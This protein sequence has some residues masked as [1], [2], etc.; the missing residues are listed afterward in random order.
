MAQ[1]LLSKDRN[2]G[3]LWKVLAESK[4]RQ[5][6]LALDAFREALRLLPRDPEVCCSYGTALREA[7]NPHTAVTCYKLAIGFRPNYAAAHCNLGVAFEILKQFGE[8]EKSYLE[9]LRLA[10]GTHQIHNNLALLYY[11]QKRLDE[12]RHHCESALGLNA[13]SKELHVGLANISM[14]A[15]DLSGA[16]RNYEKAVTE[17]GSYPDGELNLAMLL[18]AQGQF[19][20]GWPYYEARLDQRRSEPQRTV[21]TS[22]AAPRWSGEDILDRSILLHYEQGFGD[23]VQFIRYVVLLKERGAARVDLFCPIALQP[24]LATTAGIDSVITDRSSVGTYDFWCPTCSLPMIFKTT[25]DSI[26]A[27]T[28]YLYPLPERM[29]RW[30]VELKSTEPK[31]GLVWKGSSAH[32]NDSNRSLPSLEIL[33][34]ILEIC[35]L[36][37]FSLQKGQGEEE[38]EAAAA[39]G[40]LIHLGSRIEDFGDTAAIVAQLDLIICVDTAVA[41]VA[42]ALG[43]PCWVM[44]PAFC[45]DWR[46]L[47]ERSDSPWYPSLQLFRQS[48]FNDWSDVVADIRSKLQHL[49]AH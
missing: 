11:S 39:A 19:E 28:P 25:I 15:G 48:K 1:V 10:P 37:F 14:N 6:K 23:N 3:I 46:W 20:S 7:G 38:A 33:A 24:L 5:G 41:H 35:G 27:H 32:R 47:L 4:F 13:D 34:P 49:I 45:T 36:R 8:A 17:K 40:R 29:Q 16:R 30:R 22:M 2:V 42:G 26:P 18:L 31:V 44:L 9:A 43:K 12:A 21:P